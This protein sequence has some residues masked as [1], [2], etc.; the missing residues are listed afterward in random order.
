MFSIPLTRSI[1]V[2][3][4]VPSYNDERM[5]L[6]HSIW[7]TVSEEISAIW[8]E[9]A[10]STPVSQSEGVDVPTLVVPTGATAKGKI[11][12]VRDYTDHDY[13]AG[14]RQPSQVYYVDVPANATILDLKYAI[15]RYK[16]GQI[17]VEGF[18]S[19]R[20]R[21]FLNSSTRLGR[22]TVTDGLG[23][24]VVVSNSTYKIDSFGK[25][26][27]LRIIAQPA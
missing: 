10:G 17:P 1:V 20:I 18:F 16:R 23:N 15:H 24:G 11:I 22:S 13:R 27:R 19:S 3:A 14:H 8:I 7:Q 4:E 6:H 26:S 25:L 12:L 9:V 5:R 2:S 21:I